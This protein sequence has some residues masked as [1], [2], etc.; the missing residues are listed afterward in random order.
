MSFRYT[1]KP[2]QLIGQFIAPYKLI[3]PIFVLIWSFA[4]WSQPAKVAPPKK[5]PKSQQDARIAEG[6]KV[7]E[8]KQLKLEGTV[9]RPS[10]AYLMQRRRLKFKG[11]VPKKSFVSK[12]KKS[13][14]KSPF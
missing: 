14:T 3:T 2:S 13:V 9:Q 12:I 1:S 6:G 4:A 5:A 11:L 10:A 7:I 8:F